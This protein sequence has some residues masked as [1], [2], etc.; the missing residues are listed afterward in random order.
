MDLGIRVMALWH[1]VVSSDACD[2]RSGKGAVMNIS[3][4]SVLLGAFLLGVGSLGSPAQAG[5][6]LELIPNNTGPYIGGESLTVDVWLHN[7]GPPE[8]DR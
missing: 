8:W 4:M 6:V 2:C 7:Q 1:V 5:A 3:R